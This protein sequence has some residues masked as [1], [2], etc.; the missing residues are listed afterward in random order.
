MISDDLTDV[1]IGVWGP[2]SLKD[3]FT[4]LIDATRD[5]FTG[6]NSAFVLFRCT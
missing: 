1:G 6:F 5:R 4:T 3:H 2:A